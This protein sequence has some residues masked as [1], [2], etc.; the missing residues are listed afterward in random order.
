MTDTTQRDLD[1]TFCF[2]ITL[3][4]PDLGRKELFFKSVSGLKSETKVEELQEGGFVGSRKL[5]GQH[6]FPNLV[7]KRGFSGP[8]A[9][10]WNWRSQWQERTQL[11]LKR[12]NGTIEQLDAAFNTRGT[13]TF[14]R[15]WP[16]KWEGPEYD[17]SKSEIAIESL[18]I[19]HEGL[20]YEAGK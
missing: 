5:V 3:D 6:S 10:L 2:K 9:D 8:D 18:E 13:W 4:I 14:V 1:V 16:S 15:G 19:A 7:F 12:V 11:P 20:S 17:A